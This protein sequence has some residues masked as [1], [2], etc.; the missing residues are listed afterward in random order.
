MKSI[1]RNL[2][3]VLGGGGARGAFQ[4][5]ALHALLE[6]GIIPDILVGTSAGA[7]NA[8]FLAIK[9][10]NLDTINQLVEAWR[11]AAI[12]DLLPSN[13]LWLVVRSMFNRLSSSGLHRMQD[14]FVTHGVSADARFREIKGVQLFLVATDLNMGSTAVYGHNLETPILDGLLASTALPPWV[15][16]LA[17]DGKYLIDGGA[18][19]PLPIEPAMAVGAKEIIAL[20]LT[21]NRPI[22]DETRG[23]GP[24]IS[25]LINTVELRQ[26]ETEL[27]LSVSR[28]IPVHRIRLRDQLPVPIWDFSRTDELISQGYEIMIR[29][30]KDE[31]LIHKETWFKRLPRLGRLFFK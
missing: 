29:A 1:R 4:V 31:P 23:F 11:D 25:K 14:F 6:A 9:G 27:A 22:S 2:A 24:F 7:V 28:G 18:V 3:F 10:I 16:P 20:D 17:K 12:A 26:T 13:Y 15:E 8:T 21:D 19:S 5:G 30:I